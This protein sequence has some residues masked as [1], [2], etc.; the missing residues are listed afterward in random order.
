MRT[1]HLA[2]GPLNCESKGCENGVGG[3]VFV[4][5]AVVGEVEM[6]L[7]LTYKV[8]SSPPETNVVNTIIVIIS[9]VNGSMST[10]AVSF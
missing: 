5:L 9:N 6:P 10:S 1:Y 4:G 2:N 7:S 8:N 3:V